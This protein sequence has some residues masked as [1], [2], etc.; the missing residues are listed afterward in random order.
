MPLTVHTPLPSPPRH[1]LTLL[2]LT[3]LATAN[4]GLAKLLFALVFPCGLYMTIM[5]GVDLFT[6][7]TM[8]LPAAIIEGKTDMKGLAH[9]W[10]WSYFGNFVGSLALVAM[11]AYSGVLAGSVLPAKM[12]VMKTSLTWGQV[13]RGVGGVGGWG[14]KGTA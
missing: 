7:N 8:K 1:V 10:F 5:H 4:P 9:N 3:A 11:V 12:A 2:L 14:W 13:R 6:G